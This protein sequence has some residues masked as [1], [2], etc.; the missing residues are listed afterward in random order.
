MESE[1]LYSA[2]KDLVLPQGS[3]SDVPEWARPAIKYL[4]HPKDYG[5]NVTL[6]DFPAAP[7]TPSACARYKVWLE[8]RQ[9]EEKKDA[10]SKASGSVIVWTSV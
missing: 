8:K 7:E 2:E 6:A 9:A 1:K 5:L 10:V 4:R 3:E